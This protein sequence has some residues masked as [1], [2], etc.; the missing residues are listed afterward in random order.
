MTEDALVLAFETGGTK[1]VAGI[2]GTDARLLRTTSVRRKPK[3]RAPTSF[4]RILGAADELLAAPEFAGRE[5][6][7]IGFGFGGTVQRSTNS[8][9]LCL[10]EDGWEQVPVVEEL[11]RRFNAPVIVENDC[12]LAALAEAHFG[13]GA[14]ARSLFYVT[15]GTGV[16][17]GFVRAGKIQACSDLG[18]A[19]IG[20]LVVDP[21]GPECC[22]GNRGCVEAHCS[23]PGLQKLCR[24][25]ASQHPQHWQSSCLARADAPRQTTSKAIMRAW[26]DGDRFAT[27]IVERAAA[28]L[29]SALASTINLLVPERIVIG[30]G[31]GS[32][33]AR[34]LD[35]LRCLT[36]PLVVPYF[37]DS[38]E[39]VPSALRE[40]V[41]TQGAAVLAAQQ[42]PS[43][44]PIRSR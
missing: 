31:V 9:H 13:A 36:D 22:C 4:R 1:L 11:E 17:G 30:G 2:A 19:E 10:H 6:L 33:S 3:D 44:R 38:Y 5:L 8:P 14:G 7:S 20:H 43:T 28:V 42:C 37:R 25:L 26:E 27:R 35:L 15:L 23:G 32:S 34:L 41:V 18:E 16:G 29:S 21:D 39:I 12:K 40:S 24:M